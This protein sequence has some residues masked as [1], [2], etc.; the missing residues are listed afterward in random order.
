M[1][2]LAVIA[3]WFGGRIQSLQQATKRVSLV[4]I[5][6]LVPLCGCGAREP[7]EFVR[8]SGR[9]CYED[10]TPLPV[11]HLTVHFHP[12]AAAKDKNTFPRTGSASVDS[13]TGRFSSV[14][15][16]RQ[17]DGLVK[18]KHKATLHVPGRLPLPAEIASDVYSDPERTPLEIDTGE[19]PFDLRVAKPTKRGE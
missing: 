5:A 8:V 17:D 7:F 13:Q 18:G 19:S 10:G 2:P 15:S 12:R 16:H 6:L 1:L 14:T 3:Q 4:G 11:K 9:V